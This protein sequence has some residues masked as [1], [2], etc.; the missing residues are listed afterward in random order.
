MGLSQGQ[1]LSYASTIVSPARSGFSPLSLAALRDEWDAER[2]GQLTLNG[3]L[4]SAWR[5]TKNGFS[6]EQATSS[7]RPAYSPTGFNG[8]PGL[9]L[10]GVDDFMTYEGV[11]NFPTGSE[12]CEIWALVD[13]TQPVEAPA[14]GVIFSYSGTTD[15]SRRVM[16]RRVV[17][18]VPLLSAIVGTGAGQPTLDASPFV[19]RAV[20]RLVVGET[21]SQVFMN[22]TPGTTRAAVP[23][24]GIT[25]TRIGANSSGTPNIFGK[26]VLNYI[27]V[28]EP[29]TDTE[30]AQMTAFLKARGGIA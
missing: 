24:T 14:T 29:L 2:A 5:T 19:G 15:G 6:A 16:F 28:F 12:P 27:G 13:Q 1:A 30:A 10:D 26:G 25:R 3:G 4:V 11:G 21:A 18:G 8:R 17:T 22:G 20:C 9:T 23:A 7:S